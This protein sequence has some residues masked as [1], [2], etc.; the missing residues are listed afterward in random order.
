MDQHQ[1][2]QDETQDVHGRQLIIAS[3]AAYLLAAAG[4]HK[5]LPRS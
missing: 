2:E 3:A 5:Q 4:V 1:R